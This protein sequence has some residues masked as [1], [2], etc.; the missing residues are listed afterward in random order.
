MED[1]PLTMD[2]VE[3]YKRSDC[4]YYSLCLDHA[5]K[6]GWN[7]F[8]CQGCKNFELD[9][10]ADEKYRTMITRMQSTK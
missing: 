8:H 6:S 5:A 2:N 9:P 10:D 7:Q 3:R 4:K 1:P